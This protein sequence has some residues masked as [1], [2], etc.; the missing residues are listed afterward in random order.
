MR[1]RLPSALIARG[2]GSQSPQF[3]EAGSAISDVVEKGFRLE[4]LRFERQNAKGRFSRSVGPV[5][6]GVILMY[7]PVKSI[8]QFF[9]ESCCFAHFSVMISHRQ[10]HTKNNS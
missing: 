7:D 5:R 9:L 10:D 3:I 1:T 2:A 4:A 6:V 8:D